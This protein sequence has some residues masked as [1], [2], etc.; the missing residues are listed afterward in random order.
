MRIGKYIFYLI[1]FLPSL[2]QANELAKVNS[3]PLG[4]PSFYKVKGF[5]HDLALLGEALF[6][7]VALSKNNNVSCQSC[8]LPAIS[9]AD[10]N[11]FSKGTHGIATKRN[12]PVVFNLYTSNALMLDGRASSVLQQISMP[13]EAKEEMDISVGLAIERLNRSPD[14]M[15]L[16]TCLD[17][18]KLDYKLIKQSLTS[19]VA[20]LVAGGSKFDQYFYENKRGLLT[21]SE[22]RGVELF[23]GKANCTSCHTIDTTYSLFTD[24]G[25]H[26]LG[27][28]YD[29]QYYADSGRYQVTGLE[30]DKG[31]FKTPTLRNI[32]KTGP[33]MHDGSIET[34]IEVIEFYNDGGRPNPNLDRKIK[35]LELSQ[36]EMQDLVNF[37]K[38]LE[39]NVNLYS[40]SSKECIN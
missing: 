27:V 37:L 35:P 23:R 34:L 13:L 36:R 7:S 32:S 28:G 16:L 18:K 1:V 25:F 26:N 31:K 8:H 11:K 29:G 21:I 3:L 9:T 24:N 40:P 30:E 14:V 5:S 10:S 6:S 4:L 17:Y 12:T 20:S 2:A 39:S 33:Y 19:Y 15:A 22:Q 38:I